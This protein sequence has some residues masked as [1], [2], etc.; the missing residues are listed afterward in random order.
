MLYYEQNCSSPLCLLLTLV[1]NNHELEVKAFTF[2]TIPRDFPFPCV[3]LLSHFLFSPP[4]LNSCFI[5]LLLW[6]PNFSLAWKAPGGECAELLLHSC[7]PVLF[8]ALSSTVLIFCRSLYRMGFTLRL[9]P[10][11]VPSHSHLFERMSVAFSSCHYDISLVLLRSIETSYHFSALKRILSW[12]YFLKCQC[13]SLALT[14]KFINSFP[15]LPLGSFLFE[16]WPSKS[17]ILTSPL[18]YLLC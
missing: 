11:N 4:P 1:L 7:A 18:K 2:C 9:C 8:I 16:I 5:F 17:D 10:C 13:T 3:Q 12:L 14:G 15:L 6:W